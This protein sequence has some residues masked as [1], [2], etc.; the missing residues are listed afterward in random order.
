MTRCRVVH[1]TSRAFVT[2]VRPSCRGSHPSGVLHAFRSTVWTVAAPKLL[3]Q[4]GNSCKSSREE[5]AFAWI[6]NSAHLESALSHFET[7]SFDRKRMVFMPYSAKENWLER[8]P[9]FLPVFE[10]TQDGNI[11]AGLGALGS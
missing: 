3:I 5:H 7:C 1:Q 4:S 9:Q 10:C 6:E 8:Y 11:V 2:D